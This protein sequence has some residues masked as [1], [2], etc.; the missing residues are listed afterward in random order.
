MV[1]V[2]A[3]RVDTEDSLPVE[4]GSPHNHS[5]RNCLLIHPPPSAVAICGHG[6]N[7]ALTLWPVCR[8]QVF[9]EHTFMMSMFECSGNTCE[10]LARAEHPQADPQYLLHNSQLEVLIAT[11]LA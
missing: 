10:S 4:G 6:D 3:L 2:E 9:L 8:E 11:S 7:L 5:S 1:R